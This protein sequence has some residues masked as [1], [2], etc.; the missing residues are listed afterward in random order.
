M[1][2]GATMNLEHL[3]SL[4]A[5]KVKEA[6]GFRDKWNALSEEF[7]QRWQNAMTNLDQKESQRRHEVTEARERLEKRKRQLHSQA[8]S[9]HHEAAGTGIDEKSLDAE[10]RRLEEQYQYAQEAE[11]QVRKTIIKLDGERL[12]FG[13]RFP[14][15]F[16]QLINELERPCIIFATTGTTSSGKSTLVN[17]L[18]G[19]QVMPVDIEEMSA[20]VVELTHGDRRLLKIHHTPGACWDCGEW[21][22]PSDEQINDLLRQAMAK[23]HEY[24]KNVRKLASREDS[25]LTMAEATETFNSFR[26][27]ACPRAELTYPT[28]LGHMRELLDLPPGCGLKILDLPGLKHVHDEVNRPVIEEARRS[29]CLV[30]YNSEEP[31]DEVQARLL[32]QVADQV[33][34]IGGSPARMLFILNRIDGVTRDDMTDGE[35]RLTRFIEKKSRQIRDILSDRLPQY[36]DAI[37]RVQVLPLSSLPALRSIQMMN[38][39]TA[40]HAT[41]WKQIKGRFYHLVG[42]EAMEQQLKPTTQW[43][44]QDYD[45][46]GKVLWKTSR[47]EAFFEKLKAHVRTHFP[48]LVLPQAI[49]RFK[50]NVAGDL[51]EWVTQTAQAELN[52]SEE[53]YEREQRR[54]EDISTKLQAIAEQNQASLLAPL[55]EIEEK[56]NAQEYRLAQLGA[57]ASLDD[58][59]DPIIIIRDILMKLHKQPALAWLPKNSLAPLWTWR[60]NIDRARRVVLDGMANRLRGQ[61]EQPHGPIESVPSR[62]LVFV[63]QACRALLNTGYTESM[64]KARPNYHY[65]TRSEY[66]REKLKAINTALNEVA[67]ILTAVMTDTAERAARDEIDSIVEAMQT[68]LHAYRTNVTEQAIAA[69]P[70][71]GLTPPPAT[72]NLIKKTELK[73]EYKFKAGYVIRTETVTVQEGTKRVITGQRDWWNPMRWLDGINIYSTVPNF[74]LRDEYHAEIPSAESLQENWNGQSKLCEPALIRQVIGWMMEQIKRVNGEMLDFQEKLLRRYQAK[75][76]ESRGKA[77]VTYGME[78]HDWNS[79]LVGAQELAASLESLRDAVDRSVAHEEGR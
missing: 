21:D 69:A 54:V 50:M 24:V 56:L 34:A 74:V 75:L 78:Q 67:E 57:K 16:K 55:K 12:A 32:E 18:C 8:T 17:M 11:E 70:D 66:D 49:D 77:L 7:E 23:Y 61:D 30:T 73:I 59:V 6:E 62:W 31:N 63:K 37:E 47:A 42:D 22:D 26:N 58:E 40:K 4:F 27:V 76:E 35:S 3:D 60:D 33:K 52:S 28:R 43:T 25:A 53:R 13:D 48:E 9:N 65:S 79:V 64:A 1:Q 15:A 72:F 68:M 10:L 51:V 36:Q 46:V 19:A 5:A 2:F 20:G 45:A 38:G 39:D 14:I 41:A 71:I 29:V 44:S